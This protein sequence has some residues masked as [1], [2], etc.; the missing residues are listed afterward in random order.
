MTDDAIYRDRV[1]DLFHEAM[2]R[3]SE[4]ARIAF[5]DGACQG[6]PALRS[7]VDALLNSQGKI[8]S[9]LEK[10]PPL[11]ETIASSDSTGEGTQIGNY[12]LLQKLGEGGFGLV[13]MAQQTQPV[14]R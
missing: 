12:K 2:A 3:Q 8:D 11:A 4:E 7:E 13:F 6:D 5:L 10:P 14:R 9:Y 1:E